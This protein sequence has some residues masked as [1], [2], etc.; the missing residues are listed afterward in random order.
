MLL[1]HYI[2]QLWALDYSSLLWILNQTFLICSLFGMSHIHKEWPS[3]RFLKWWTQHSWVKTTDTLA[4]VAVT[5][6]WHNSFE[7]QSPLLVQHSKV[8]PCWSLYSWCVTA[9][10]Q[11]DYRFARQAAAADHHQILMKTVL[12]WQ[13]QVVLVLVCSPGCL[14]HSNQRAWSAFTGVISIIIALPFLKQL[15]LVPLKSYSK[16]GHSSIMCFLKKIIL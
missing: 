11:W 3:F 15:H 7:L 1:C 16:K 12:R 8:L 14:Q 13:H 5:L 6:P 4:A 10:T 2:S 9:T